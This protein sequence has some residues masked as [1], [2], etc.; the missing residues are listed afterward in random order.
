MCSFWRMACVIQTKISDI[1]TFDPPWY[2]PTAAGLANLEVHL[3]VSCAALPVFW[4]TIEKTLD[5]IFVTQEV[6]VTREYGVF[7]SKSNDVELQSASSDKNL[8]LDAGETPEGWEPFVGDETTGL[9]ENE[10]VVESLT[11]A[12]RSWKVKSFF[13]RKAQ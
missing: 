13:R 12:K 9:G 2:A 4:P 8:T 11:A 1:G 6:S 10:T 7:P 5:K 3:A